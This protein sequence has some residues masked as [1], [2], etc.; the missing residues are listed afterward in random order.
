[1]VVL[2]DVCTSSSS[3]LEN[4]YFLYLPVLLGI[5][6]RRMRRVLARSL[7]ILVIPQTSLSSRDSTAG[8]YEL[9]RG[10]ALWLSSVV[11]GRAQIHM[12]VFA[13]RQLMEASPL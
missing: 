11:P 10:L 9:S 5:V 7:E 6:L 3:R 8:F 12:R 2:R 13:C 1:V 4:L